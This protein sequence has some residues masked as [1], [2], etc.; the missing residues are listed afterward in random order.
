MI[1]GP[2]LTAEDAAILETFVVP[3][4]LTFFGELALEMM[5]VSQG[6]ARVAH[7]GCRV[8]YPDRIII[9]QIP[10]STVTGVDPSR[11]ALD[12]ARNK[13]AI[14]G[15]RAIEY[16]EC[17]EF[18]TPLTSDAFSHVLS[19][20]PVADV[21]GRAALFREMR[22]LMYSGGQALVALPLR[23]SF[24]EPADL[25][26]EYALKVDDRHLDRAVED[27]VLERPSI[28][29]LSDELEAAGFED[30]D[31]E[32]RHTTLSFPSGRAFVED[33]ISRLLIIPEMRLLLRGVE[34]GK[35]LEYLQHA[36]DQYWSEGKFELSLHVGCASAR[37]P[38]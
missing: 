22:R 9:E 29:S 25:L 16:L 35:P 1:A 20:H 24:Q 17:A 5:L 28:E 10:G 31:V 21:G 38:G 11:P 12:L 30:V 13:S 14:R 27:S 4:Y 37:Q 6:G 32:I 33:P 15:S 3:R 26:R 36:I 19:L 2:V 34:L 8:G 7:L 23:G 18:P